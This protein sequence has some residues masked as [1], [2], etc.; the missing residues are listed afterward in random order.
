MV[1]NFLLYYI[2]FLKKSKAFILKFTKNLFFPKKITAANHMICGDDDE[3][4]C[5][6]PP[7]VHG[8]GVG[9]GSGSVHGSGSGSVY[10][11]SE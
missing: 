11:G 2:V 5:Y 1:Y 3:I 4:L 6:S 10:S 9:S 7:S 8:S